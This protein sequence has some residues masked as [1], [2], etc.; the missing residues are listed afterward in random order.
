MTLDAYSV[1]SVWKFYD[2]EGRF[3]HLGD[4][5]YWSI[6]VDSEISKI[7]FVPIL[8][9]SSSSERVVSPCNNREEAINPSRFLNSGGF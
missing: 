8:E 2:G 3:E 1:N 9:N 6:Y 7:T 5:V 4:K